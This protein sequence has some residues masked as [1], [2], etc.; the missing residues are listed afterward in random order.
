MGFLVLLGFGLASPVLPLL[1]DDLGL[2]VAS[3]GA[4]VGAFAVGR[5]LFGAASIFGLTEARHML[6]PGWLI[7]GCLL[8]AAAAVW[9]GVA[10]DAVQLIAARAVQGVGSAMAMLAASIRPFVADDQEN[11]GRRVGNQQTIFLLGTAVGPV[12]GGA[13]GQFAGLHSPFWVTAALALCAVPFGLLAHRQGRGAEAARNPQI[14]EPESTSRRAWVVLPV[15]TLVALAIVTVANGSRSGFRTTF[16]PIWAHDELGLPETVIGVALGIGALGFLSSAIVGR[17]VDRFGPLPLLVAG[18]V[19][20]ATATG[21]VLVAP[22]I[23]T[24]FIAMVLSTIGA[25]SAIVGASTLIIRGDSRV[26][27]LLAVR[28]QR[29]ATDLGMLLG[30]LSVGIALGAWAYDG[31]L[32]FLTLVS[33]AIIA[34]A[35]IARPG[36]TIVREESA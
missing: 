22:S 33:L 16:F 36:R 32:V 13:L 26:E 29:V 15:V 3:I 4:A 19:I 2:T 14:D 7:G 35:L 12:I 21:L 6:H 30:P 1:A 9:C 25:S 24:G 34:A 8:T 18:G 28:N 20:L 23:P 10:P 11:L 5:L 27:R 17:V 31:T